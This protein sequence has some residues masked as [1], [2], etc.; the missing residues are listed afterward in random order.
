[1]ATLT[2]AV[3]Y[4]RKAADGVYDAGT[5]VPNAFRLEVKKDGIKIKGRLDWYV[6]KSQA[7]N[8]T[9]AKP[10]DVIQDASGT[11]WVVET[12]DIEAWGARWFLHTLQER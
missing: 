9:L 4:Y 5:A 11:R 3:T 12:A 6:W 8:G 7:G 10:G 2:E 1:M